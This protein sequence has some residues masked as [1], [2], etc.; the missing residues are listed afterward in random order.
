MEPNLKPIETRY[1]NYRFRS[2]TEAKWAVFWDALGLRWEYEVEGYDLGN[3]LRYLPDFY[4]HDWKR[5]VEIK[6]DLMSEADEAA[7]NERARYDAIKILA[8]CNAANARALL[9]FGAPYPKGTRI[10]QVGPGERDLAV[11]DFY[12]TEFAACR[13]CDG[14]CAVSVNEDGYIW[15]GGEIAPELH[16]CGDH[17]KLP[18][19]GS[20][21]PDTNIGRAYAAAR[22]ARFEHGKVA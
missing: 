12:Y 8:F 22:D 16:T 17:D 18:L 19:R 10:Y 15:A 7:R 3:G 4:I 1:G 21:F 13:R 20:D 2:R 9:I 6:P 14:T 5:Y 11:D